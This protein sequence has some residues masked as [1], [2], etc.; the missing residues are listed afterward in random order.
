MSSWKGNAKYK[1]STIYSRIYWIDLEETE[2]NIDYS[3]FD[4]RMQ[5]AKEEK[6]LFSFRL[7]PFGLDFGSRVPDWLKTKI[8]E[9][10]GSIDP[11]GN[12]IPNHNNAIFLQ[13]TER[14]IKL[15]GLHVTGSRYIDYVD[16]GSIGYWGE[17]HL[18]SL[19]KGG[20]LSKSHMPNEENGKKIVDWYAEAFQNERL[21]ALIGDNSILNCNRKRVWNK[22]RLFR[23]CYLFM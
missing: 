15:I 7:M 5:I 19:D 17:N 13:E 1:H 16:I 20:P 4:E 10:N 23:R 6:K 12:W 21:I 18:Y 9:S 3:F 11:R 14:I 22:S 8:G 2:G